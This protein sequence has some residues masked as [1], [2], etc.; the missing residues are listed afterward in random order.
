MRYIVGINSLDHCVDK[1]KSANMWKQRVALYTDESVLSD[2][3]DGQNQ[4]API[5]KDPGMFI[6]YDKN[7][8]YDSFYN[9]KFAELI[10]E[11]NVLMED[12]YYKSKKENREKSK[13]ENREK[14]KNEN[15]EVSPLK[16]RL[17]DKTQGSK[18]ENGNSPLKKRAN[19]LGTSLKTFTKL[20]V[21]NKSKSIDKISADSDNGKNEFGWDSVTGIDATS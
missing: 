1:L 14:T 13:N 17:R 9:E 15:Q 18:N 2:M 5:T 12:F 7:R 21:M 16:R 3:G 4:S 19:T 6:K 10:K 20:E 8:I 11:S